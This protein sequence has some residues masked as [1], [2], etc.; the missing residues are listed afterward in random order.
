[1]TRINP[2]RKIVRVLVTEVLSGCMYN[3]LLSDVT[4][5]PAFSVNWRFLGI[6]AGNSF[7]IFGFTTILW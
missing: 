5:S 6:V 3:V 2:F 1:M 4:G 7:F